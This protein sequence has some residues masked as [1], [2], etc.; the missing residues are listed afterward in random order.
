[1]DDESLAQVNERL[2]NPVDFADAPSA[3]LGLFV[4]GR[5]SQEMG[6]TVR[7]ASADPTGEGHRRGTIAFIDLPNALLSQDVASTLQTDEKASEAVARRTDQVD[8]TQ[9]ETSTGAAVFAEDAPGQPAPASDAPTAPAEAPVPVA[10]SAP[11]TTSAGFPKRSKGTSEAAPTP[12]AEAPAPAPAAQA[13]PTPAAEAAPATT[14]AGF[15]KRSKG[16]TEVKT[17]PDK[18]VSSTPAIA[19][20]VP[21]EANAKPQLKRDPNTSAVALVNAAKAEAKAKA[22]AEAAAGGA[23]A[24]G[25]AAAAPAPAPEPTVAPAPEAAP[26]PTGPTTSA[27]FPKRGGSTTSSS[28]PQPTV[29]RQMEPAPTLSLIHISEPT[30]PY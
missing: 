14:T 21:A 16:A 8:A 17:T 4:V 19:G 30:R 12:A 1:M 26:A 9:A 29:D 28:I 27:G 22:A 20:Q 6:V 23:A 10:E 5:L 15:P 11:E 25:I 3:Y 18:F 24:A 13:A 7:L 2:E